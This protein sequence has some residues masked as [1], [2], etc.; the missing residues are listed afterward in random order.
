M[1][2]TRETRTD[3]SI[4]MIRNL[5]LNSSNIICGFDTNIV[6]KDKKASPSSRMG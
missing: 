5:M 4:F 6:N 2:T 3:S 1:I